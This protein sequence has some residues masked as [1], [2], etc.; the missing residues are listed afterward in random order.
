LRGIAR[1]T[2]RPPAAKADE[3]LPQLVCWAALIRQVG[4]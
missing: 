4:A 3:I 2:V 1:I